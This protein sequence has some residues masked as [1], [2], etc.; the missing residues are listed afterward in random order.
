MHG[1]LERVKDVSSSVEIAC[2]ASLRRV[3]AFCYACR[4]RSPP[5]S[6]R[7]HLLSPVRPS[8]GERAPLQ[9]RRTDQ[10]PRSTGN[11][12]RLPASRRSGCLP[13]LRSRARGRISPLRFPRR[14]LAHAAHT[15]SPRLGTKCLSGIASVSPGTFPGT[16]SSLL[17]LRL[18]RAGSPFQPRRKRY[19]LILANP[20]L[21]LTTQA[22]LR[23][24]V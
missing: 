7:G 19:R 20:R 17:A 1:S 23:G 16:N 4:R 14:P 22:R 18:E 3:H 13:P 12:R 5:R 9:T 21:G 10:D 2:S 8:E 24:S 11:P 15:F 6:S